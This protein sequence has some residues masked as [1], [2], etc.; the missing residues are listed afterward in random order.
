MV[1][2]CKRTSLGAFENKIH[3]KQGP[4]CSAC[5][6]V[7]LYWEIVIRFFIRIPGS[8]VL[9]MLDRPSVVAKYS[10]KILQLTGDSTLGDTRAKIEHLFVQWI[11]RIARGLCISQHGQSCMVHP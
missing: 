5:F 1:F 7:G 4:Q 9:V 8:C 3:F 6:C 11:H 2:L 10:T